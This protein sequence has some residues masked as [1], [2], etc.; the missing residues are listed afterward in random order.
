ML[1]FSGYLKILLYIKCRFCPRENGIMPERGVQMCLILFAHQLRAALPLVLLANRDEFLA[2]AAAPM[3]PWAEAP[4]VVGGRDLVAGGSWL[5]VTAS[6]RWAAVTNVREGERTRPDGPS[7]GWL[8]RD[9]LQGG[10]APQSFIERLTPQFPA[11]AGFNLL[12]GDGRDVWYVSNRD[13][14]ALHLPP[15]LYG[16]SNGRLD[17]PWPKVERGKAGLADLLT[18]PS[19]ERGFHLLADCDIFPDHHL[20]DTGISLEWERTLS[21]AFIV[22]PQHAYGTRSSTVL[23]QSACGETLLAERSFAGSPVR[24]SQCSYRLSAVDTMAPI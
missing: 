10:A 7:R 22:A 15:G 5:G 1:D 18:A 12:L 14:T 20:P 9:F 23:L 16:L 8:V 13:A 3:A 21:A 17:T 2:R 6:G 11:Y 19:V 24:W 4:E